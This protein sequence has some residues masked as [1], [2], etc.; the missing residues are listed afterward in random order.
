MKTKC[1]L[2][3]R[4][5][6][7]R[8]VSGILVGLLLLA[9]MAA[10][11]ASAAPFAYISNLSSN[12]VTV[13]DGTTVL[14]PAIPVGPQPS[15]VAVNPAGTRVYVANSNIF[16]TGVPS[17]SVI[18]TA[19]LTVLTTIT[20][21]ITGQPSGVA[22]SDDGSLVYVAN[23]N[24]TVAVIDA[25]SNT[26]VNTLAPPPGE[27]RQL[28]AI[29]VAGGSVYATDNFTGEVVN[30]T[31]ASMR[32]F[33]SFNMMG[34]TANASGSRLY[35]A[36]GDAADSNL[37]IAIIDPAT[38]FVQQ[39]F[40]AVLISTPGMDSGFDAAGIAVSP[41]G[42]FVYA[43]V[44]NENKLAVMNTATNAV[45]L[46][47]V[48]IAPFGVAVDPMGTRVYVGNI[49]SRTATVL[50]ATTNTVVPPPVALGRNPM[51]FG[52]FVASERPAPPPPQFLLTLATVGS[53]TI[54]A[55]PASATGKYD[56]GTVV[57]LTATP[58]AGFQ[59]TSWSGACSGSGACSVT[60]DA[61][62]SVTATFSAQYTLFL[63]TIGTGTIA[64][65]PAPVAGKYAAGT[66]VTLT[67]TPDPGF[68]FTSWSG[69]CS[70]SNATC[71]V[72]M[73]AAKSVTATFTA[74]YTLFLTAI[75]NGTIGSPAG[76]G[77]REVC[78][79]YRGDPHRHAGRR[80]RV[81]ELVGRLL[82]EQRDLQR[83]DGRGQE[84]DRDLHGAV[85]VDLDG[86]RQR[87]DRG[88]AV[89]GGR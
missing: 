33:L 26:V 36:Y 87:D 25:A 65:Q 43:S 31:D 23:S 38:S 75:G 57:T 89:A 71:S 84:R 2:P 88:R 27:P 80:L 28:A 35:V 79:G 7:T 74:Q 63:T 72:T 48:G 14:A 32:L 54:A 41:S 53:G 64:P 3:K 16:D 13:I 67:A 19:S 44:L 81:H 1:S 85:R 37:K 69:A 70:G 66:V 15:G 18:D 59:F 17:V 34:I 56:A 12:S 52:S 47:T 21:G 22:V 4:F 8:R 60:M 82:G 73:D 76:S 46:I 77:G 49:S 62:K 29:V 55:Q 61:A 39:T 86:D 42:A 45:S 11:G 5:S 50:D 83:D 9:L 68:L 40:T 10:P 58:D 51:A 78:R 24:G 20:T 6:G 30:L